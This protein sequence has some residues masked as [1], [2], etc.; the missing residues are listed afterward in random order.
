MCGSMQGSSAV[1]PAGGWVVFVRCMMTK[2]MAVASEA[3]SHWRRGKGSDSRSNWKIVAM[4]T[5]IRPLKKW[6]KTRERG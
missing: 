6:P 5:P 1:A 4:M 3:A 2:A